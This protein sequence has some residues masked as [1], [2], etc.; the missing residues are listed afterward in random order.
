MKVEKVD[1]PCTHD[2]ENET[3]NA[4]FELHA[5]AVNLTDTSEALH[6]KVILNNNEFVTMILSSPFSCTDFRVQNFVHENLYTAKHLKA[7]YVMKMYKI[8][9]TKFCTRNFVHRNSDENSL[10]FFC[11]SQKLISNFTLKSRAICQAFFIL[12]KKWS[13]ND[14]R[15]LRIV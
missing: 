6:E 10:D 2:H 3:K 14:I 15:N 13:L 4:K 11:S 7:H 9:C 12:V 8:P 1:S 5:H